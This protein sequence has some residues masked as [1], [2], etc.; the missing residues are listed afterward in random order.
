M[1]FLYCITEYK[2]AVNIPEKLQMITIFSTYYG[3][4]LVFPVLVPHFS[5][6]Y[7]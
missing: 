6:A 7:L 2:R 1:K 3:T 5:L 4:D